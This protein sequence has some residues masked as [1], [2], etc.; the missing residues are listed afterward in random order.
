[1]NYLLYVEHSAENLQFYLWLR[2]YETRF[3]NAPAADQALSPVWTVK[4]QD[5]ASHAAK[6]N[7]A[8]RKRTK[9]A[10]TSL[11]R[12]TDFEQKKATK[13]TSMDIGDP[14]STPPLTRDGSNSDKKGH[15]HSESKV[16][17]MEPWDPYA[18]PESEPVS[19]YPDS[20]TESFRKKAGDAF[21]AA[22]LK[23]PCKFINSNPHTNIIP[24]TLSFEQY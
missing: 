6:L 14:F 7:A 23:V 20:S 18:R 13:F 2:A 22:G 16:K 21:E 4:Q 17:F 12:G 10:A 1:M 5:S 8:S 15:G 24:C 9:T 19:E 11:F 3:N